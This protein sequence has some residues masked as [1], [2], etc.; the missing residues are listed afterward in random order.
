MSEWWDKLKD[1]SSKVGEKVGEIAGATK[2]KL[3]IELEILK[4]GRE[5][6]IVEDE[7]L[8]LKTRMGER[9]LELEAQGRIEDEELKKTCAEVKRLNEKVAELEQE[10]ER[11]RE[12][13]AAEETEEAEKEEGKEGGDDAS[14]S[15]AERPEEG[16]EERKDDSA[17]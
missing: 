12:E 16:G 13:A 10:I 1:L 9:V 3:G 15:T 7:I 2:K 5:K 4:L 14:S 6:N 17:K 11:L 8:S